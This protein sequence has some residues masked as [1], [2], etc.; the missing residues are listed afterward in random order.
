MDLKSFKL[1]ANLWIVIGTIA[2]LAFAYIF[3]LNYYIAGKEHNIISTRFRVLDQIGDNLDKKLASYI[4]NANNQKGKIENILGDILELDGIYYALWDNIDGKSRYA[5]IDRNKLVSYVDGRMKD[6]DFNSALKVTGIVS[7]QEIID[8]K[9]KPSKSTYAIPVKVNISDIDVESMLEGE[10]VII[11]ASYTNLMSGLERADVFDGLIVI[12]GSEII[13]NTLGQDM[14]LT[15]ADSLKA[16]IDPAKTNEKKKEG[17]NLSIATNNSLKQGSIFSGTAF[18]IVISNKPHKA[19]LKPIEVHGD[20]WYIMGLMERNHYNAASRSIAPWIIVLLSL[21][22]IFIILGLPVFKLKVMSNTEELETGTIINFAIS[23]LLGG[24]LM[25]LFLFFIIQNLAHNEQIDK[26]LAALSDDIY[27]SFTNEITLASNQ[28]KMYDDLYNSIDFDKNENENEFN[29]KIRNNILDNADAIVVPREYPFADYYFWVKEDGKQE[30][31]MTPFGNFGSMSDLSSRDYV[32]KKDEWYFVK[33]DEKEDTIKL[34]LESIVSVTSGSVKGALS[35]PSKSYAVD[36][37]TINNYER[38]RKSSRIDSTELPVIALSSKFYSIIDPI[39]PKN[40]AFCIIDKSGKVWFHSDKNLNLKENFIAECDD[41]KNLSAALY[42]NISSTINVDYYNTPHK[43]SVRPMDNLPLYLVTLYN[44]KSEK[45]FQAQAITL[46]FVLMGSLYFLIFIQVV[47]LL[48][49]ERKYQLPLGKNILMKLTRP[50]MHFNENYKYLLNVNIII[51]ILI[52]PF[53]LQLSDMHAVIAIFN[54]TIYS[55][56][57]MYWVLNSNPLKKKARIWFTGFNVFL[58]LVVNI[59]GGHMVG[60]EDLEKVLLFQAAIIATTLVCHLFFRK[61]LNFGH[62]NYVHNF[63]LSLLGVLILFGIIPALKFYEIAFNTELEVRARHVQIDLMKQRE[64]RN[65]EISK[66]YNL[67]KPSEKVDSIMSV[68]KGLGNYTD[69][70]NHTKFGSISEWPPSKISNNHWDSLISNLRPFYDDNIIENK[71]LIYNTQQNLALEWSKSED[72]KK[73]LFKYTSLTED[74]KQNKLVTQYMET[75]LRQLQFYFPFK[76]EDY[77]WWKAL[78]LSLLFWVIVLAFLDIFFYLI[79]F[80]V[81]KIYCLDIVEN[82][83]HQ[84]FIDHARHHL[85][86]CS[87]LLISRLSFVDETDDFK[88]EFKET[89]DCE[90]INWSDMEEV[91]KTPDTIEKYLKE[92]DKKWKNQTSELKEEKTVRNSL[93]IIIDHFDWNYH[94][95][96]ILLTKMDIVRT[97]IERD[98]VLIILISQSSVNKI[99]EYY[100]GLADQKEAVES[101]DENWSKINANFKNLLTKLVIVNQ[102]VNFR[103]SYKEETRKITL[104]TKFNAE[105][106]IHEELRAT[107]YLRR[108][109]PAM[110]DYFHHHSR[111]VHY[112]NREENIIRRINLLA[113]KYYNDLLDSCSLEEK[114]VLYDTADDLIVN[115]RNKNAILSLLEKGLLIKKIDRIKFMNISFRRFVLDSLNKQDTE[116]IELQM[117]KTSGTWKGYRITFIIIIIALFAFIAMANQSFFD[118][119]NEMFVAIGGGLTVITSVL[120]VLS[121]KN[122]SSGG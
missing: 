49:V 83:S 12:N 121:R 58:L 105:H 30:S 42:R 17:T 10:N 67:I 109:E 34:R 50:K 100:Q 19:F 54:L 2:I 71:Y 85:I 7:D 87:N 9:K 4:S 90:W 47:G 80:G 93:T 44:S 120:G 72:N 14:I 106:L 63:I 64:D 24:S 68:R 46:T 21:L 41:N 3:Y 82:Y 89:Y 98:D 13:Y 28:L 23:M 77:T 115:P 116:E 40:Y 61:K 29:N 43:I 99:T 48:V 11:E 86:A 36:S 104:P 97:F 1:G 70:L 57:Y 91:Q 88:N 16:L 25:I 45:S 76:W 56:A 39:V 107:D 32:N 94:D 113:Q 96:K 111:E 31:Y 84:K 65:A 59:I 79:R 18:D 112:K 78:L 51:F 33:K 52:I 122:K 108:L 74:P 37:L 62:S 73:L 69:F 35:M 110:K 119:I 101:G 117:G 114:Y 81:R 75:G 38:R 15:S 55:F 8:I 6:D 20:T 5:D 60:W 118:N 66:Y 95:P 103:R 92:F 22:L 27:T 53:I 102:S 26:R